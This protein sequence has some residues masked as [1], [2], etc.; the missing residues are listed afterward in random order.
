VTAGTC[1]VAGLTVDIPDT[2]N[3]LFIPPFLCGT[4]DFVVLATEAPDLDFLDGVVTVENEPGIFFADPLD[5]IDPI[6]VGTDP[7]EQDV[8]VWQPT[9]A[10]DVYEVRA[11]ELTDDCGSSR[12]STRGLSYFVV[13]MAINFGLD[14]VTEAEDLRQAFIGLTTMKFDALGQVLENAR[15]SLVSPRYGALR[16]QWSSANDNFQIGNYDKAL[17]RLDK[18][19]ARVEAAEFDTSSGFNHRGNLLMRARNIR[20][21]IEAK[22]VPFAP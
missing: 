2:A 3:D 20:F 10:A 18:F 15:T 17:Q 6:P 5:C 13:G 21:M 4:P 8:V 12:G 7:Q 19:I 1:G 11:L 16:S 22:V 9:V 14:H